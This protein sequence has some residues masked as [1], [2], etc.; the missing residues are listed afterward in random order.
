M[1][2]REPYI[3]FA[4]EEARATKKGQILNVGVL[5]SENL[6]I[7]IYMPP[8]VANSEVMNNATPMI[9]SPILGRIGR[10]MYH[11]SDSCPIQYKVGAML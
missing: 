9:E 5:I 10:T 6:V 4:Y 3:K 2:E 7:L 8:E 1:H 11:H